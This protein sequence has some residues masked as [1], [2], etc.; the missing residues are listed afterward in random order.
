MDSA[1]FDHVLGNG[2]LNW[3]PRRRIVTIATFME[4]I[5]LVSARDRFPVSHTHVYTDNVST[6]ILDHFMMDPTLMEVVEGAAATDLG[7]NLSCHSPCML[8]LRLGELPT[9]P[10]VKVEGQTARRPA[11]YKADETN[12]HNFKQ[13]SEGKL[14]KLTVPSSIHFSNTQ[15]KDETH[16]SDRDGFVLDCMGSI[17]VA[18]QE[19]IPMSG[20]RGGSRDP[21][22]GGGQSQ[23]GEGNP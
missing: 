1:E 11:W 7:D 21:G 10:K 14:K 6:S 17:I 3:D 9:R 5:G 12:I 8:K 18:S 13:R 22:A 23:Q 2:D 19:T 15:C 20:G 4:R 16:S